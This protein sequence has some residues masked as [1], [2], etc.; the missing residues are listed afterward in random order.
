MKSWLLNVSLFIV[1]IPLAFKGIEKYFYNEEN[2]YFKG[3]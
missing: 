3:L 2:S 1:R